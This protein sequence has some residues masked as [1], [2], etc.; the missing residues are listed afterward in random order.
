MLDI[1]DNGFLSEK[2]NDWECLRGFRK[3][4]ESG[5]ASVELPLN[6]HLDYTGNNWECNRGFRENNSSCVINQ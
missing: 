6:A 4:E 1:P 5:C 3:Q 2:G